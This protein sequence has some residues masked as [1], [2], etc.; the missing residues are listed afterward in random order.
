MTKLINESETATDF[1]SGAR[2][3]DPK[4]CLDKYKTIGY[5]QVVSLWASP[6]LMSVRVV[7]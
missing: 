4:F 3:K 6:V 5:Y 7:A 1:E 2:K